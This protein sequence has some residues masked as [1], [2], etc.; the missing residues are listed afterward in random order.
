M[1]EMHRISDVKVVKNGYLYPTT[2]AVNQYYDDLS[3]LVS[4]FKSNLISVGIPDSMMLYRIK[5]ITKTRIRFSPYVSV[6]CRGDYV[7]YQNKYG[8]H[9]FI[10][11]P[12]D[13]HSII[14]LSGKVT[15]LRTIPIS[16]TEYNKVLR[17]VLYKEIEGSL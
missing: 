8:T 7:E 4:D 2:F 15:T 9:R 5:D 6:E 12:G 14:D 13:I 10:E 1:K 16:E 17:Q 11:L 3:K